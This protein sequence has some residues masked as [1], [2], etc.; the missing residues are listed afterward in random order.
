MFKEKSNSLSE[1]FTE[2]VNLNDVKIEES[3]MAVVLYGDKLLTTKEMIFGKK[4]LSL[5]K[6]HKEENESLIK[7]AIRE[8]FEETNIIIDESNLVCELTPYLYEFLT[9]LNRLIKKTIFPFLF[10][11]ESAGDPQPKEQR[12]VAVDWMEISEFLKICP[13]ENVKTIIKEIDL[14]GK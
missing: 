1:Q 14:Y 13:Y 3:A 8:C 11:V 9:P 5:P 12:I 2:I 6:G 7:T 10:K 4:T